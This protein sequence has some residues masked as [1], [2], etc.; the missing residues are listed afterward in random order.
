MVREV[1]MTWMISLVVSLSASAG[2][3]IGGVSF[4]IGSDEKMNLALRQI[5][6]HF[7]MNK[8]TPIRVFLVADG[9]KPALEGAKDENGGDYT[10]QMEQLLASGI[11]IFACENTLAHLGKSTEDLAFGIETITSGIAELG[12]LQVDEN[13]AYIKL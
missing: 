13:W 1:L 12:R 2:D 7:E 3:E 11:R 6:R 10:A 5:T 9:V 8:S 4:H